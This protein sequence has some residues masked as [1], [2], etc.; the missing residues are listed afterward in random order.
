LHFFDAGAGPA[1]LFV[2]NWTADIFKPQINR[3]S[4]RFRVIALDPRSQGDS[5][6]TPEG[7]T[8]ERHAADIK[9]LL[10]HL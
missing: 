10:Q 6:K 9:E 3:R 1:I 4:D 5:E 8:L 2:P 7:N